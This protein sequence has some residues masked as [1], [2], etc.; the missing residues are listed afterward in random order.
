MILFTTYV[1]RHRAMRNCFSGRGKGGES[2]KYNSSPIV[3]VSIY[4]L[5]FYQFINYICINLSLG[6]ISIYQLYLYQF[7]NCICFNLSIVVLLIHQCCI[8]INLSSSSI[9]FASIEM[10]YVTSKRGFVEGHVRCAEKKMLEAAK[11][12][13]KGCNMTGH[14]M[15]FFK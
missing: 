15:Y 5:Y 2:G 8:C 10:L 6:F 13:Y 4:Q 11:T 9:V 12:I 7:I 1:P 3:F 14:L